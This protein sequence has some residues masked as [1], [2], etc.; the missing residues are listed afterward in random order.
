MV[1]SLKMGRFVDKRKASLNYSI[2]PQPSGINS[3]KNLIKRKEDD[4]L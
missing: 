2:M 3:I 1:F 4:I